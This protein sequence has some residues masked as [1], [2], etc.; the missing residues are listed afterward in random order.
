MNISERF[1]GRASIVILAIGF[2]VVAALTGATVWLTLRASDQADWVSHTMEVEAKINDISALI[3]RAESARRGYLI[4]GQPADAAAARRTTVMLHAAATELQGMVTD[5]PVEVSRAAKLAALIDSRIA[6]ITRSLEGDVAAARRDFG[7]GDQTVLA[8]IGDLT[9]AMTS[10]ETSL[11]RARSAAAD[12]SVRTLLVVTVAAAIGI[13]ALGLGSVWLVRNYF[14]ALRR[15][16]QELEE[17]NQGLEEAVQERT[18]DVL[19]AN[20][21]IQRFAYVV[22]HDLRAPLVNIMGFTSEIEAGLGDVVAALDAAAAQA[23]DLDLAAARQVVDEDW[24]EAIGFIRTSSEKMDR[25][26]N[27][28]LRL[29]RE[30]RR[31][32]TAERLRIGEVVEAIVD[33]MRHQIEERGITVRVEPLPDIMSDRLAIEQIFG[34]LVDN[35]VKYLDDSRPGEIAVR[36]FD[37]G[38]RV[39]FEVEDNGRGIAERDRE[40]VFDLFRRAGAQDRPGEGIGLAHVRTLVRRLGGTI[41]LSSEL[42]RGTTFRIL[43]PKTMPRGL[44]E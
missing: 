21:E 14:Q 4:T 41:L 42:G 15:S 17:V 39:E 20:A 44:Q 5:N 19:Q 3:E 11:Q 18:A 29:S 23:P 38:R 27:A 9:G 31:T 7:T 34:N 28:I 33:G 43:M 36:G 25:L 8:A 2:I 10:E 16:R 6:R 35:A 13:L 37:R 30:G 24:P 40:R 26:I 32:F 1:F 12:W 22:S